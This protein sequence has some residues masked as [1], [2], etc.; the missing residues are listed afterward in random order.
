MLKEYYSLRNNLYK[1]RDELFDLQRKRVIN[2]VRRAYENSIYYKE[3]LDKIHLHP[4]DLIQDFGTFSNIPLLS[5]E[6]L[7]NIEI[8]HL[9]PPQYSDF[10]KLIFHPT[11][12]STG[13]PLKIYKTKADSTLNDLAHVRSYLYNGWRIF[14]KIGSI[15]G[16]VDY[17]EPSILQRLGIM[18]IKYILIDQS[19]SRIVEELQESNFNII[20]AYSDDL[21]LISKYIIDNGIESIKPRI[22]STGAALLDE[23][24]KNYIVRAFGVKPMDSYGSADAGQIAWQ[25]YKSNYHINIDMV[26]IEVLNKGKSSPMGTSGEIVITNLWNT[27]FPMIRFKLGDIV[28]LLD[29]VCECGCEFPLLKMVD[30]KTVDFIILP[31]GQAVAPHAP[32]QVMSGLVEVKSYKI[33]QNIITEVHVKI[34]PNPSFNENVKNLIITK[35][36]SLFNNEILVKIEIVNEI[37]RSARK[38][39]TIESKVGQKYFEEKTI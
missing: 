7:R 12:G 21:F 4:E 11:S 30:G 13:I 14:D 24:T 36:N 37:P 5:K 38:F 22:V 33:I 25:C 27:A 16:N 8:Q 19:I 2:I 17:R 31:S 6:N 29:G 9:I 34:I 20:K 23:K 32:K 26:H 15:I 28:T 1:S 35:M 18:P 3:M 10:K 39:V